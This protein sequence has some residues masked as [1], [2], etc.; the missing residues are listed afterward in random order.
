MTPEAMV[1]DAL[2]VAALGHSALVLL[3][4]CV[5]GWLWQIVSKDAGHADVIW[6]LGLGGSALYYLALGDGSLVLRLV[7]AALVGFW[8]LRLA[9]HIAARLRSEDHEDGRYAA[10]RDALGSKVHLFHLFFFLMQGLLAWLFALPHWVI[11]SHPGPV[12]AWALLAAVLVAVVALVGETAADNTLARWRADPANRGKT[13]R[14]GL[15]RYSRHPNYFFEWLHWFS[16]P[17][18]ALGAPLAGWVWLAPA[19]MIVFLWFVT[20]IPYTEKQAIKS[21]GDD[22]RDYQRTTSPFIPWRPGQ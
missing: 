4:V 21:R 5:L 12:S 15:W 13:C 6:A 2:M 16:Y 1:N 18:L 8:S 7:T 14:E 22:Y 17:L 9:G 10:M 3:V 19:L 20:G 11:A